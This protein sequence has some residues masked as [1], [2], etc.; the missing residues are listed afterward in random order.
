MTGLSPN[1][2]IHLYEEQIHNYMIQI[3]DYSQEINNYEKEVLKDQ[4]KLNFYMVKYLK[5][6]IIN[7]FIFIIGIIDF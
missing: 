2:K 5:Y 3:H 4:E 1:Q 7:K 6:I